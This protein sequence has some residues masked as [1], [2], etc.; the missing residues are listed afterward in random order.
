MRQKL[1]WVLSC[2]HRNFNGV[3]MI[4][5]I[6]EFEIIDKF[7]HPFNKPAVTLLFG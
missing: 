4:L 6:Y 7:E 1:F 3:L 2:M 5:A